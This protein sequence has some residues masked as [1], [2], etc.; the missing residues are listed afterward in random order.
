MNKINTFNFT[1]FFKNGIDGVIPKEKIKRGK[2]LNL[3]S[4]EF[5]HPISDTI[6]QD[7]V[8][9]IK[10]EHI[11]QY[12]YHPELLVNLS[13]FY[14][15]PT[16]NLLV[17]A[18]SDDAI[19]IITEAII[20]NSKKLIL[21]YPN[22][23]NYVRYAELRGVYIEKI[24]PLENKI[25]AF[26][27]FQDKIKSSNSSTIVITNPNGIS[28][29]CFS[30]EEMTHLAEIALRNNNLL[31]IDEAYIPFNGFDHLSI[32]NNF[33]NV[34]LI[35]SFSK[36]FGVAG[37]RLAVV[38]SSSKIIKYLEKWNSAN[39]IT[40]MSIHLLNELVKRYDQI[41]KAHLDIINAR[42]DISSYLKN[43]F[44]DWTVLPTKG[45][46]I[47]VQTNERFSSK[48]LISYFYNNNII[49]RDLSSVSG[50]TE[51]FR[52]TV[53]HGEINKHLVSLFDN[54]QKLYS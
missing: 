28:G 30:L 23:E 20:M 10:T 42:D 6:T 4:N 32:I 7:I 8:S 19:K 5:I 49:L 26:Q 17:S 53:P 37:L 43:C 29:F 16:E 50:F 24:W 36:S 14:S 15:I 11:V 2:A 22:Y 45:N 39:A 9:T 48:D 25:Y 54:Y 31:I 13:E 21:Q 34:I 33:D 12:N 41:K 18:G 35:R 51:C 38:F 27:Q 40:T 47:T 52:M 1:P 44:S 46:F 3:A